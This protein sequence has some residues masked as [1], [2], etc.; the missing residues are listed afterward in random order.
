MNSVVEGGNHCKYGKQ[1]FIP[2]FV[3]YFITTMKCLR[4]PNFIKRG[5]SFWIMAREVQNPNSMV[6]IGFDFGEGITAS[7]R[8]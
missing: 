6:S 3:F 8:L 5:D 2:V 4:Q 7:N 1:Q